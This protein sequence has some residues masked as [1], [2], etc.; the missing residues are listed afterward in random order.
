MSQHVYCHCGASGRDAPAVGGW[1]V[2]KHCELA[3]TTSTVITVP[4]AS[5]SEI[6]VA[7]E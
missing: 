7:G 6:V 2:Y 1:R 3:V 4:E 5:A